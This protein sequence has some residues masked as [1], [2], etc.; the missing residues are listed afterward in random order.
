MEDGFLGPNSHC[1]SR[2]SKAI[3]L[4]KLIL[5]CDEESIKKIKHK[6]IGVQKYKIFF[7]VV[8]G[9]PAFDKSYSY[10]IFFGTIIN[11]KT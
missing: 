4:L 9:T 3:F 1:F 11:S 6:I 5:S 2:Y 7:I 10:I 8:F